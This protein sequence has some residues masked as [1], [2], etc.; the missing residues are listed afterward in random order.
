M[1]QLFCLRTVLSIS[2][3]ELVYR[4]HVPSY[5]ESRPRGRS[6]VRCLFGLDRNPGALKDLRPEVQS[7]ISPLFRESSRHILTLHVVGIPISSSRIIANSVSHAD[8]SRQM[9]PVSAS[10]PILHNGTYAFYASGSIPSDSGSMI[11][12]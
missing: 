8:W 11:S 6:R 4:F 12:T 1:C 5:I 2:E 3:A 7:S 9:N 10:W